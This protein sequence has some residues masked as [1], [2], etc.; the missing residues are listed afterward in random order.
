MY[1]ADS[2]W[3]ISPIIGYDSGHWN[4]GNEHML[5]SKALTPA[6][7]DHNAHPK[8]PLRKAGAAC[9][10]R[11]RPHFDIEGISPLPVEFGHGFDHR[12][13]VFRRDVIGDAVA[14]SAGVSAAR[15][16]IFENLP[17]AGANRG[18]AANR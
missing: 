6:R 5:H 12:Q 2:I 16:G 15:G 11:S 7:L 14:R 4:P 17:D 10:T 9:L 18:L 13:V 8:Q 1:R 3:P